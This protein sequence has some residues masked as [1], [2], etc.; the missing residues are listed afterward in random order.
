VLSWVAG[1][2]D[3]RAESGRNRPRIVVVAEEIADLTAT[4]RDVSSLI[5]RIAQIGRALG[6]HLI[7]TTQQ[8]G[9]KSLG[10][11]LVNFPA[12]CLG[13]VASSTLAYGAAGRKQTGADVLLGRGDFLLVAAG[14]TVRFQA[15]L[16]DSRQW[17]QL[18]RG[19]AANLTEQLPTLV[20]FGDRNRD[21]RGGPGRRELEDGDYRQI[22]EAL[23]RGATVMD[24]RQRFGIGHERANRIYQ[25]YIEERR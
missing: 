15:P 24:L 16:A 20:E 17:S 4:N 3:R 9:A 12:R 6:V 2:L 25:T 14:E 22:E 5:A 21:P 13:R 8:P 18:P 7:G 10:D 23:S 11:A 1:E 19:G